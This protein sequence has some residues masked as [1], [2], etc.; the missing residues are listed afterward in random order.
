MGTSII[1][2]VN[3]RAPERGSYGEQCGII[4]NSIYA[5]SQYGLHTLLPTYGVV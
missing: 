2:S 5:G 3:W 4:K 1:L